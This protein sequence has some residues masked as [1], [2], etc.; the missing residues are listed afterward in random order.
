MELQDTIADKG[1]QIS[2]QLPKP[3]QTQL[4]TI[5]VSVSSA[6]AVLG[7]CFLPSLFGFSRFPLTC[8]ESMALSSTYRKKKLMKPICKRGLCRRDC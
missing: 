5:I 7:K 8:A 3:K 6:P 1:L 4:W 2:A